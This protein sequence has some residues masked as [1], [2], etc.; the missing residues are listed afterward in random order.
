MLTER[1]DN[2]LVITLNRP[3][4]RNAVN[5]ELAIGVG[6]ALDEL[7]A[8]GSLALGILTGS[9]GFFCAFKEKREPR[10]QGR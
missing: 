4:V 8:D 7:D 6:A 2:V 10:W 1:R 9:D 5:S 3:E